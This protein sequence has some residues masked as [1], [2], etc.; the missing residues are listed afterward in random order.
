MGLLFGCNTMSHIGGDDTGTDGG[1][2]SATDGSSDGGGEECGPVTC[3]EGQVCCNASCGICTSPG[4][5]CPAIACVDAG[6]PTCGGFTGEECP[7]GSYCDFP[8]GCGFADGSGV[9]EPRPEGCTEDCPGVCGCDGAFYCNGC[10]AAQAGIDVLHEGD[11]G[12]PESAPMDARGEGPC[13]LFFGFAWDGTSCVGLGGCTCEGADC[14]S[15]YPGLDE[16]EDAHRDCFGPPPP[17]PGTVCGGFGGPAD[18][19][20]GAFCDYPDGAFCGAADE[21]GVCAVRPTVC[22]EEFAPVCGCDGLTYDNGCFAHASG[23]DYSGPGD[24]AGSSGG[25]MGSEPGAGG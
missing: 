23:T 14:G 10:M 13:E 2:D 18:C 6:P 5:A 25:G 9:C 8:E 20:P 11:C 15:L 21:P 22:T 4:L 12:G 16:C 19:G 7:D 24:C 1:T 3:G 17:P